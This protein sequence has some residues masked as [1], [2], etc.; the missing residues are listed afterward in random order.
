MD[1]LCLVIPQGAQFTH[2]FLMF[3]NSKYCKKYLCA[4]AGLYTFYDITSNYPYGIH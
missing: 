4:N 3:G 2:R 1:I